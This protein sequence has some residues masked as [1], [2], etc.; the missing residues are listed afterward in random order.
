MIDEKQNELLDE[1]ED[2]FDDDDDDGREL[3]EKDYDIYEDAFFRV[4]L[5]NDPQGFFSVLD[6]YASEH[7]DELAPLLEKAPPQTEK[8]RKIRV[9][10]NHRKFFNNGRLPYPEE[11]NLYEKI[12]GKISYM[13]KKHS[14]NHR[15]KKRKRLEEKCKRLK[16]KIR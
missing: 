14:R 12:R 16:K 7:A 9:N 2:D 5:R 1:E 11:D 4:I 3:T 8:Q 13:I 6:K 10:R 15:D